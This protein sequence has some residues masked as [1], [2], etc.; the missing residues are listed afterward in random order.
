MPLR[1]SSN[2]LLNLTLGFLAFQIHN[3]PHYGLSNTFIHERP[4]I[5][6]VI[7]HFRMT[8]MPIVAKLPSVLLVSFPDLKVPCEAGGPASPPR[9]ILEFSVGFET[10]FRTF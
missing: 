6:I 2:K 4:E 7:I 8:G 1:V 10:A 9:L 3:L 5:K